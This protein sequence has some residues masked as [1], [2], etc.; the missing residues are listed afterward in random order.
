MHNKSQKITKKYRHISGWDNRVF[1]FVRDHPIGVPVATFGILLLL[2]G[3]ILFTFGHVRRNDVPVRN[4]QIVIISY[5]HHEQIVPSNAPTVG[6]LLQ[7]LAIPLNA[8]DVVEP[9]LT[10]HI[11]QDNFRVN[12]YRALPVRI[13]DGTTVKYGSSAATT[14][15]SIATQAGVTI[16]P[17]D[18]LYKE[19]TTEFL[20][21]YSIGQTVSISRSTPVN[22]NLYGAAIPTRTQATTVKE[23]L[24]EKHIKISKVDTVKPALSSP[25][26]PDI[27]VAVIRNGIRTITEKHDIAIPIQTINDPTLSYGT[28]AIR[29]VG[30]PGQEVVTYQVNVQN[31][32]EVSRNIL[33]SVVVKPP[34]TQIVVNG[35]NLGG[36]KGDMALAGIDPG[37][38]NYVD[39]IVSRESGWCPTKAQGQYGGCPP[40]AGS[41]PSGGG[42]G[43]CQATPG[44]KM[45]SAGADWA[46]N[47][48]TQLRWCSGY[49]HSRYGSWEAAYNHWLSYHNW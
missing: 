10:T 37:D 41:V 38:Y 20:R 12:I 23:L 9:A 35:V 19:A 34:V 28:S 24:A 40:Y 14:A 16:Y 31:G 7:K 4:S 21:D 5:D 26:T 33:Q 49:A 22:L 46:T 27:A 25:I 17:E 6:A 30:S 29:Q 42:Y 44:S 36:I 13:V 48:V 3:I 32:V 11:N 15:R 45:A 1:N 8:G 39:Y 43:L 18:K 2:S 47:P